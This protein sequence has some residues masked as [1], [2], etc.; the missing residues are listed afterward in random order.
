MG[1]KVETLADLLQPGLR[2]VVVGI[3]PAPTSVA[4]GHYYHGASGQTFR[5]TGAYQ[6][7]ARRRGL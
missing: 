6:A 5:A 1:Q 7:T 3:N 4:A 2:A